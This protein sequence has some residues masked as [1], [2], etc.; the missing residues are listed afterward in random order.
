MRQ[1]CRL[2]R[3]HTERAHRSA[4]GNPREAPVGRRESG[5][6]ARGQK[7]YAVGNLVGQFG[8]QRVAPREEHPAPASGRARGQSPRMRSYRFARTP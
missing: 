1:V 7:V 5:P 6:L 2:P 8:L 4:P 3:R